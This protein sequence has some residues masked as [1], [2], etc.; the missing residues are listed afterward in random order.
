MY[1]KMSIIIPTKIKITS[2]LF[3]SPRV[4]IGAYLPVD[5]LLIRMGGIINYNINC[6]STDKDRFKEHI[7][8]VLVGLNSGVVF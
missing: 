7:G 6:A 8:R 2:G 1:L 3:V 4:D 5:N